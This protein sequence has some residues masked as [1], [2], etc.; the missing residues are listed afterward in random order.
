MKIF[1][2]IVRILMGG[3]FLFSSIAYFF[4]LIPQP[5]HTGAMKVFAEGLI[6]SRYIFP[7]VKVVEFLCGIAFVSGFFVPSALVLIAPI[8]VN[9]FFIHLFLDLSGLPVAIFLVF[10]CLFLAHIHREKFLPFF[11]VK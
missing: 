11:S 3:L 1:S 8:V 7:V 10:A 4:N 5:E 9:I 6:A 2:N